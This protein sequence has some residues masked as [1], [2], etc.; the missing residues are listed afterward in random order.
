MAR[1][2]ARLEANL[3]RDLAG[4]YPRS[5]LIVPHR[6]PVRGDDVIRWAPATDGMAAPSSAA[7]LL[8]QLTAGERTPMVRMQRSSGRSI[9]WGCW[10][11]VAPPI[12]RSAPIG[13]LVRVGFDGE[14][15]SSAQSLADALSCHVQR[16][17]ANSSWPTIYLKRSIQRQLGD[18]SRLRQRVS[19]HLSQVQ[20]RGADR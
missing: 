15:L 8:S 12:G 1:T 13:H 9:R 2:M 10:I 20:W 18:P 6:W 17:A 11:A 7:Q 14:D 19:S 3:A 4:A 5:A 16:A